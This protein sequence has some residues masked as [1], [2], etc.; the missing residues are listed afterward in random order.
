MTT[1][2]YFIFERQKE[3]RVE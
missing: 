1:F 2:S 3:D